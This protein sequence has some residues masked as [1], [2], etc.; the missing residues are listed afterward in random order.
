[1]AKI[2]WAT[3]RDPIARYRDLQAFAAE[4]GFTDEAAFFGR[5]IAALEKP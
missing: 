4:H 1:M 5:S 3:E 2:C